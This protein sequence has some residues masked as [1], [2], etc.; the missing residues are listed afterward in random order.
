MLKSQH[1][2][3]LLKRNKANGVSIKPITD[4]CVM[5]LIEAEPAF[6]VVVLRDDVEGEYM[7][8]EG[9]YSVTPLGV[10]RL[11]DA[12]VQPGALERMR[13]LMEMATKRIGLAFAEPAMRFAAAAEKMN[14]QSHYDML[15][16]T[17]DE[18]PKPPSSRHEVLTNP[19]G[20]YAF[21]RAKL[22]PRRH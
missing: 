13:I 2:L 20:N 5:M 8:V 4:G 22:K 12:S 18:L 9:Y 21:P 7:P 14:M 1:H 10:L 15:A 3:E 17:D 11:L 19:R 16:A 6:G